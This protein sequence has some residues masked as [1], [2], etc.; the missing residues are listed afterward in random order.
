MASIAGQGCHTV[1]ITE[2]LQTDRALFVIVEL[3]ARENST[4]HAEGAL[5]LLLATLLP[6]RS[7]L[8]LTLL[9]VIILSKQLVAPAISSL[10]AEDER[11]YLASQD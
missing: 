10:T 1:L 3:V 8:L 5:P 7:P 2:L 4:E 9:L 6:P 11:V